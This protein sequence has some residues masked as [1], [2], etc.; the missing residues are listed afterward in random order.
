MGGSRRAIKSVAE[1]IK[2][3]IEC[4]QP[5][6]WKSPYSFDAFSLGIWFRGQS[7]EEYSLTPSIFRKNNNKITEEISIV[8]HFKQRCVELSENCNNQMEWLTIMQHYS[9]PTRL[10]DWSES[11]LIAL[12][13][14]VCDAEDSASDKAALYALNAWEL[15][16]YSTGNHNIISSSDYEVSARTNQSRSLTKG[17]LKRVFGHENRLDIFGLSEFGERLEDE[18]FA[19]P[20]AVS[21]THNSKRIIAQQGTMTVH[22]GK[23]YSKQESSYLDHEF[24]FLYVPETIEKINKSQLLEKK[25][26][27][28]RKIKVENKFKIKKE[29]EAIGIHEGSLFPEVDNQSRFIRGNWQ[30]EIS[31]KKNKAKKNSPGGSRSGR[32][33]GRILQS[34]KRRGGIARKSG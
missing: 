9:L 33:S 10:L 25:P 22:G 30:K 16:G 20:I 14:A 18:G 3:A 29:L 24:Q 23:I 31:T 19:T 8:N 21:P 26:P 6:T 5:K 1:V 28:F 13:F 17:E 32:G 11:P 4:S 15:N 34:L 12:Y 2:F 7:K 27:V